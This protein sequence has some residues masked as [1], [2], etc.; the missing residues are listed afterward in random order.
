MSKSIIVLKLRDICLIS[1][2]IFF[3]YREYFGLKKIKTFN[4]INPDLF[5]GNPDLLQKL[6]QAYNGRLD[7]IDVYIGKF[8]MT[9]VIIRKIKISMTK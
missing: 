1:N 5:E 4:E 8:T 3:N 6:I 2:D 7:N 9:C